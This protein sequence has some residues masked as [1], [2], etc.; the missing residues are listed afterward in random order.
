MIVVPVAGYVRVTRRAAFRSRP[1]TRW[2]CRRWCHGPTRWPKWPRPVHYGAGLAIAA[3]IC[4]HIGAALFHGIVKRDGVFSRIWPPFG[5]GL[6]AR[7]HLVPA[8]GWSICRAREARSALRR[9]IPLQGGASTLSCH[10]PFPASGLGV[11][12]R[13]SPGDQPG[14]PG[15]CSCADGASG[16]GPCGG[17]GQAVATAGPVGRRRRRWGW[18][19]SARSGSRRGGDGDP[20]PC[21]AAERAAPRR[22]RAGSRRARPRSS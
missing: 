10:L 22:L 17:R 20:G 19:R 21:A 3:L 6:R 9:M 4:V 16:R 14:F 8:V 5:G 1:S 12:T 15:L 18:S 7:A 11:R 2:A 13:A